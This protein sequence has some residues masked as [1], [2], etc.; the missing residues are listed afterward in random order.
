MKILKI[1]S[2]TKTKYRIYLEGQLTFFLYKGELSRY[3]LSEGT[4]LSALEY[5]DIC[6]QVLVKRAK[7]RAMHLLN[8]MGRT[9]H[10][11]R[12]KLMQG[13]YPPEVIDEAVLYVKSFGYI[14]DVA[15]AKNFIL[16]RKERK[17]RREIEQSLREKGIDVEVIE[18][19]FEEC[20]E[21]D[22]QKAAIK[23]LLRKKKYDPDRMDW[24]QKQKMIGFLARKGFDYDD[25]RQVIQVPEWNS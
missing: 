10:Q 17:S 5:Q 8:T 2:V 22:D 3:C 12:K 13:E 23:T 6:K 24:E 21:K 20:Y 11:L 19:S 14:N 4:E 7:M 18:A 25:I 9:E 16:G 15:Y 1:E